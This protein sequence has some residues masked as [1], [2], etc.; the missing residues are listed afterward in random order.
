M[1]LSW[2]T[3]VKISQNVTG[4]LLEQCFNN[5]H[6][7]R[8]ATV[9]KHFWS[10]FITIILFSNSGATRLIMGCWNRKHMY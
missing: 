1:C 7:A 2:D 4:L 9:W 3:H 8:V 6:R 10:I 5:F